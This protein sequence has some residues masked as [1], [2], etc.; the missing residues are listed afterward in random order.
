MRGRRTTCV[1][2]LSGVGYFAFRMRRRAAA[3]CL[4]RMSS[5][6][7]S[8]RGFT[9]AGFDDFS[10][11]FMSDVVVDLL[12]RVNRRGPLE[13]FIGVPRFCADLIQDVVG[14]HEAARPVVAVDR[15][16]GRDLR[17]Y[18]HVDDVHA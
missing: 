12:V 5:S 2:F 18:V 4:S 15:A 3:A 8:G 9:K 11:P 7:T 1:P 10:W 14:V 6:T 17:V 16:L 13:G